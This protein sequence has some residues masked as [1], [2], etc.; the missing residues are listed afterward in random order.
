MGEANTAPRHENRELV[1]LELRP[2]LDSWTIKGQAGVPAL[3]TRG[4]FH[5]FSL[6]V[7]A[8]NDQELFGT[9]CV[10]SRWDGASNIFAHIYCWLTDANNAKNFRLQLSWQHYTATADVVPAT[11]SEDLIVETTTG[12]VAAFQSYEV[13][14]E[15]AFGALVQD[16]IIGFRLYRL[17]ATE[18]EIAGNVVI[19]HWG[20]IFRRDKLGVTLP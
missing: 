7:Y 17:A 16:D 4:I 12:N 13:E 15:L 9:M 11:T 6:P 20:I 14:F 18:D 8:A 1:Y 19:N 10:P 5:G 2:Q 3:V